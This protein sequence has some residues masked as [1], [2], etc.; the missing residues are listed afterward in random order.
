MVEIVPFTKITKEKE[1]LFKPSPSIGFLPCNAHM[2][3][4]CSLVINDFSA[5]YWALICN[6]Y[7]SFQRCQYHLS[8]LS[9]ISWWVYTLNSLMCHLQKARNK[10]LGNMYVHTHRIYRCTLWLLRKKKGCTLWSVLLDP[11]SQLEHTHLHL[12]I[13]FFSL[14]F[15]R[16]LSR[17]ISLTVYLRI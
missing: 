3:N 7:F 5:S 4:R 10:N 11:R 15:S 9:F 8:F 2:S 17:K 16:N 14:F 6:F 13:I 1:C 12:N